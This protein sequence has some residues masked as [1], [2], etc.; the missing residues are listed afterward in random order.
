MEK[1]SLK[2]CQPLPDDED[3][4]G[5]TVDPRTL[6]DLPLDNPIEMTRDLTNYK[7]RVRQKRE[8]LQQAAE[9]QQDATTADE[10]NNKTAADDKDWNPDADGDAEPQKPWTPCTHQVFPTSDVR[11][12]GTTI[13]IDGQ[14]EFVSHTRP[15]RLESTKMPCVIDVNSHVAGYTHNTLTTMGG[16]FDPLVTTHISI[17]QSST[18][19]MSI[20]I[21]HVF[22]YKT[23]THVAYLITIPI[24]AFVESPRIEDYAS[25]ADEQRARLFP[26]VQDVSF[27]SSMRLVVNVKMA[28]VWMRCV[29]APPAGKDTADLKTLLDAWRKNIEQDTAHV[30]FGFSMP[31]GQIM[32]TSYILP[33]I[34]EYDSIRENPK[35]A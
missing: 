22:K 30:Q 19:P 35:R 20:R 26:G 23:S 4:Y 29:G 34:D 7:E 5:G 11:R 6:E 12:T 17:V 28:D 24:T 31:S 16:H 18:L 25:N 9:L 3:A 1:L 2:D 21:R 14:Q 10:W 27:C 13:L 8:E 15:S 33:A 32:L